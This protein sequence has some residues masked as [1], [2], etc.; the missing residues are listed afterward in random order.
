MRTWIEAD[1]ANG[2]AMD[3]SEVT[4]RKASRSSRRG[5][6]VRLAA[7]ATT[8]ALATGCAM[9]EIWADWGDP[10][11]LQS[12]NVVG[13][14]RSGPGQE[15]T[16]ADDGAFTALAL[17]YD[18]FKNWIPENFDVGQPLDGSGTWTLEAPHE[19]PDGPRSVVSLSFT[20][21]AGVSAGRGGPDLYAVRQDG[22]ESLYFFYDGG[23]SWTAYRKEIIPQ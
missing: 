7:Y 20:R 6:L 21:L 11:D 2:A 22:V 15:I 5:R 19:N 23:T 16:F 9:G 12:A 13:T 10:V 3:A 4:S 17:P 18:R 14:W 1:T 8:L